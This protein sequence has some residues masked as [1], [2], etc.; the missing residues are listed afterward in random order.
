MPMTSDLKFCGS[1]RDTRYL[2]EPPQL[3]EENSTPDPL[4]N[5]EDEYQR[6]SNRAS[7]ILE[8]YRWQLTAR[9]TT[10][11]RGAI[12]KRI[13]GP[14]WFRARD[15]REISK[16]QVRS[17]NRFSSLFATRNVPPISCSPLSTLDF[18]PR[19]KATTCWRGY[20][21]WRFYTLKAT[22][23]TRSSMRRWKWV[24]RSLTEIFSQDFALVS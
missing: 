1:T 15:P 14:E 19:A 20:V 24:I 9:R 21:P 5:F 18:I 10:F 11:D 17:R 2:P 16:I 22:S 6:V 3:S 13:L 12:A 8:E 7:L 4:L 23:D